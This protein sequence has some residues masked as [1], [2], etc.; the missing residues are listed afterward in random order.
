MKHLSPELELSM[1]LSL[2]DDAKVQKRKA[3]IKHIHWR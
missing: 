2:N 1:S 3:E